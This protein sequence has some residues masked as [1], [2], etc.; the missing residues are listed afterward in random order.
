MADISV[1]TS[2]YSTGATD[3]WT[4]LVNNVTPHDARQPNGLASAIL[5]IEAALGSGSVLPGSL[6]SLAARL[7]V[8]VGSDGIIIPP[9]AASLYFGASAP[10]G[11]L[12]CDG[13]AISRT[14]YA[15]LFTALGTTYGAGDG[16]TTFNLPDMRGRF[17]LG[18]GTGAQDGASGTGV[19]SGGTALTARSLG[20][21]DGGE[22]HTLV[23]DEIPSHQH[24]IVTATDDLSSGGTLASAYDNSPTGS[25]TTALAGGGDP[26]NN[27]PPFLV[28]NLI[29]KT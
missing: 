19:I 26:H 6:A 24:S 27:M 13:S 14:T 4:T 17:P 25:V 8:Q 2:G 21:W 16:S 11:W 22:T 18:A 10:T 5:Q 29:I 1:S 20:A 7:A 9:G 28:M 23:T 12:F 3:T 15:A